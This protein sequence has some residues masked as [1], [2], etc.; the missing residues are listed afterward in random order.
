[1]FTCLHAYTLTCTC[2]GWANDMQMGSEDMRMENAN[3]QLGNDDMQLGD[4]DMQ[5]ENANTQ[6]GHDDMQLGN[7]DM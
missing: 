3:M 2:V 4:D 1:M 6:L 7:N 5:L